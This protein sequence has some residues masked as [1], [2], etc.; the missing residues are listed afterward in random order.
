MTAAQEHAQHMTA[1]DACRK[2]ISTAGDASYLPRRPERGL[3]VPLP[4]ISGTRD[5]Q[6]S[7]Y[8]GV[9]AVSGPYIDS[10]IRAINSGV[11][12]TRAASVSLS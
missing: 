8:G 2:G 12:T 4:C 9:L 1:G 6:E 11:G 7:G 3:G 5:G 10:G